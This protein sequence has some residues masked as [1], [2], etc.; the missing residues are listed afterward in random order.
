MDITKQSDLDGKTGP[1]LIA[2]FNEVANREKKPTVKRFPDL[3]TARKRV[4][5]MIKGTIERV[6]PQVAEGAYESPRDAEFRTGIKPRKRRSP[7]KV[8]SPQPSAKPAAPAPQPV[9]TA[10]AR[11]KR[12]AK[13]APKAKQNRN[14]DGMN[15]GEN[16][17]RARL[18][19][20][21]KKMKGAYVDRDIVIEDVYGDERPQHPAS[22]LERVIAGIED[23]FKAAGL[24]L[25]VRTRRFNNVSQLGLFSSG[26]PDPAGPA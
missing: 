15:M 10:P 6:A 2:I 25:E 18:Y 13:P 1:E 12:N 9:A 20:S 5:E 11:G 16:T 3:K 17:N 7:P 8:D 19:A 22:A 21:L 24:K 14:I 4:W 23:R 26:E